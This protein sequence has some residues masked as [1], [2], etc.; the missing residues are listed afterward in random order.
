MHII[1][2]FAGDGVQKTF[3]KKRI[4]Y[5]DALELYIRYEISHIEQV[6]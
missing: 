6:C 1:M 2:S 3:S 4:R 5:V